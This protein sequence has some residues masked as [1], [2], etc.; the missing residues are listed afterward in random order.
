M[1][2]WLLPA[3]LG[4][5]A[6]FGLSKIKNKGGGT[7]VA[8]D[9]YERVRNQ[10]NDWLT[11]TGTPG[12]PGYTP[13]Q[14]GQPG[15]SYTGEMVAPLS[16]QE[17]KSFGFLK[18]Y[19]EQ[20][21][22]DTFKQGQGEISKT[23][24][25]EYDPTTSPYYQAVKAHS[26]KNLEETQ[27]NIASNAAG[28]GRYWTGARLEQ[29]GKAARESE[30]G[31]NNLLGVLSENER[32]RR[33]DVLPQALNF[34]QAEQ[35]LPLEKASA[36]QTLGALPR[37]IQQAQDTS[38]QN[39][40]LRSQVEYPLEIAKLASNVQTPPT[41]QQK[42]PSGLEQLL[43]GAGSTA[44]NIGTMLLMAKLFPALAACWVASEIFGG[45]TEPKTEAARYFVN[46]IAP[47]WFKEFYLRY[48]EAIAEFIHDK[49]IFKMA[50]RPLFEIFAFIG[51]EKSILWPHTSLKF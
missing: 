48:G 41:Y 23:L 17:G 14:I 8:A 31:L 42:P 3:L 16:E 7:S 39:E 43:T 50:L 26:A 36:F 46:N 44:G 13:G 1:P 34:G 51:K 10:L 2:A 20:G 24:T 37:N 22:G 9:P 49:P 28:G 29:E 12:Q 30:L 15:K 33:L 5:A 32:Q 6:G 35:R 19:G 38:S 47:L 4:G 40:W 45:W 21:Y 25:N 11:G 27:R 18:K